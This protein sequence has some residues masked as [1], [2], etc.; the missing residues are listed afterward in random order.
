MAEERRAALALQERDFTILL[1]LYECRLMSLRHVCDLY[2]DGRME[3]AKK[4]IQKLKAAG[5]VRE[6]PRVV[7]EASV[8]HISK[9]AFLELQRSGRLEAF[10][11]MPIAAMEKRAH[12]RDLT[13]RHELEVM[14]VRTA[15][16]K[17]IR[18]K[19]EISV[20]EFS[21]W[22]A[23]YQFTAQHVSPLLGRRDLLMKPDGFIRV[24]EEE[25]GEIFEHLFFLEVD[26]STE[27]QDLIA[28][29][30]S[31]Y[32]DFYQKGGMAERFGATREEFRNFPFRVLMVFRN[33]ERRNNAAERLLRNTPPIL[34]QV[35]LCAMD[36]FL[37]E[38]LGPIWLRPKD[39]LEATKGGPFDPMGQTNGTIYR[40]QMEREKTVRSNAILQALFFMPIP[41]RG[42]SSSSEE[43]TL[44]M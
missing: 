14:D 34:S 13:L 38:P 33:E 6:R 40:R 1:G 42:A 3:S 23:L 36:Q 35:W 7:G 44:K 2:F 4:R 41:P 39:Y 8:L 21:T 28:Q 10:P 19:S 17:A 18:G 20:I 25:K 30:A 22:P 32:L 26:R 24:R 27:V 29:K 37:V 15:F 43:P 5:L 31:C 16:L 9:Q 11:P 12:V